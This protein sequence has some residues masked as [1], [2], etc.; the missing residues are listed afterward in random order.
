MS[1]MEKRNICV[2]HLVVNVI[3]IFVSILSACVGYLC[4][5]A[6]YSGLRDCRDRRLFMIFMSYHF[7]IF[8]HGSMQQ[9]VT[10]LTSRNDITILIQHAKLIR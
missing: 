1:T 6:V 10:R 4:M 9:V 7:F 5:S 8:D 3:A 2:Y